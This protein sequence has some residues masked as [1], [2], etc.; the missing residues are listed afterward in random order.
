LF[1]H[2]SDWKNGVWAEGEDFNVP[3]YAG[4][5]P[6]LALVNAHS[7][8]PEE[9]SFFSID[10]P[11]IVLTGMKKAEDGNE[12]IVRLAEIEGKETIIN[13]RLPVDVSSVRRLN[14]IE[15]P[16]E[17]ASQPTVNGKTI[18]LKIKPNEIVTLGIT[19]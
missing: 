13:L 18:H 16:L 8:C 2:V 9:A 6:S 5:P 3:V 10:S 15:L 14:L 4:E 11:G 12:L 17:N 1:P 19:W 7:I